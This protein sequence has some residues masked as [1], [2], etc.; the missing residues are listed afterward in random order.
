[1]ALIK[2][3]EDYVAKMAQNDDHRLC[4]PCLG[5]GH[6]MTTCQASNW[7]TLKAQ[8]DRT[9]RLKPMFKEKALDAPDPH[10][11]KQPQFGKGARVFSL[12]S[13]SEAQGHSISEES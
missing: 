7:L 2:K 9:A 1:M 5:E 11:K 10:R 4:L 3:C 12:T 6:K 8:E 13:V